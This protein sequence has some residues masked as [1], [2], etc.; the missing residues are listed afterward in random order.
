VRSAARLPLAWQGEI[1]IRHAHPRRALAL[2]IDDDGYLCAIT[3]AGAADEIY[4]KLYRASV[5]KDAAATRRSRLQARPACRA[6]S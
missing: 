6:R 1:A 4:G 3:L 5:A 2:F